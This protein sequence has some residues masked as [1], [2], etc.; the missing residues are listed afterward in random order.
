[1]QARMSPARIESI[2]TEGRRVK[3]GQSPHCQAV[4]ETARSD[5]SCVQRDTYWPVVHETPLVL[6]QDQVLP[7]GKLASHDQGHAAVPMGLRH[8]EEALVLVYGSRRPVETGAEA[9][10]MK[11]SPRS[12]EVNLESVW[13][14]L[15]VPLRCSG[16]SA[17]S[18]LV[19]SYS[20]SST[21]SITNNFNLICI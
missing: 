1:M 2:L 19:L 20:S 11:T 3:E 17:M 9:R 5:G 4:S 12:G 8:V 10:G 7:E 13:P 14:G 16:D 15:G 6:A 18:P 21:V